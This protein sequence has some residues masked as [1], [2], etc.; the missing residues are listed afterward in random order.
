M[1]GQDAREI[2]YICYNNQ[3]SAIQPGVAMGYQRRR[4]KM[5]IE[6]VEVWKKIIV[7]RFSPNIRLIRILGEGG[8]CAK[9]SNTQIFAPLSKMPPKTYEIEERISKASEAMD[10]DSTLKGTKQPCDLEPCIIA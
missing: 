5:S 1:G 3:Q 6:N 7:R 4:L 10:K 2:R 9:T 8:R